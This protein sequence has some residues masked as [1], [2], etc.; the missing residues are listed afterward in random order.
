[1]LLAG[2][3][4]ITPL[5][6]M[7]RH[8]VSTEPTR[9]VTLVYSAH[10][11]DDFAFRD[12]LSAMVHRH[13]QVRVQLAVTSGASHPSIYPGRIDESLLRATVPDLAHSIAFICGPSGM[14]DATKALLGGLGVPP[15]QIRHE[16]F[17]QAVAASAGLPHADAPAPQSVDAP[18]RRSRVPRTR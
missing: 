5:I 1:M 4:G 15:A 3:I 14:I 13:P 17:Q 7:L 10:T 8:A 11:Q 6:S 18:A 12:E 16:V 9:P 2:G